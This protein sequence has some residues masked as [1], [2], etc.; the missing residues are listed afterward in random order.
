MYLCTKS[1]GDPP[2]PTANQNHDDVLVEN[3]EVTKKV[4]HSKNIFVFEASGFLK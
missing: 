3:Q 1:R 4:P 2:E